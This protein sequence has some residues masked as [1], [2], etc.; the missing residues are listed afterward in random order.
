MAALESARRAS[1]ELWAARAMARMCWLLLRQ[2]RIADAEQ[3]AVATADGIEP[4]MRDADLARIS[5]WGWLL[6]FAAAAAARDARPDAARDML[7]A[8]AAGAARLGDRIAPGLLHGTAEFGPGLVAMKRVEVAV[9]SGDP[10]GALRLA[11]QL[12]EDRRLISSDRH[13]HR[14]DIAYAR[15]IAGQLP[16]AVDVLRQVRADAPLWLRHQRYARDIVCVIA[17]SRR[18]T[19][20]QELVELADFVGAS[21]LRC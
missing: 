13:R 14:L 10:S 21:D 5:E 2:G 16:E 20:T 12:P 8:A 6:C 17:A 9:V 3:V 18:R 11:E 1:D 7:D 15:A 4:R 19:M